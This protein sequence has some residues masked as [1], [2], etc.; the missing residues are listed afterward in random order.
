MCPQNLKCG[1]E[2][3]QGLPWAVTF[4]MTLGAAG[5]LPQARLWVTLEGLSQQQMSFV[6]CVS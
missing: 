3:L 5:P 2:R 6:P 4:Q 1:L